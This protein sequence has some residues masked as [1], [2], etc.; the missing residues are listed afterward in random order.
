MHAAEIA[1]ASNP[2]ERLS[3]C[4]SGHSDATSARQ[5][6]LQSLYNSV[7]FRSLWGEESR[8][9]A[10]ED[11]VSQLTNDGLNIANY[12]PKAS[13][14]TDFCHDVALTQGYLQALYDLRFG[15]VDRQSI[16]PLWREQPVNL[17][18]R[19]YFITEHA[20]RH[21]HAPD[22]AFEAVRPRSAQYHGLR[23][24]YAERLRSQQHDLPKVPSGTLLKPGTYDERVRLIAKRLE[25]Q[26]YGPF[27]ATDMYDSA[28]VEA[29]KAFQARYNLQADGVIGPR[30]LEVLNQSSA[31][32]LRQVRVNLERWR[33]LEHEQEPEQLLV[34][35][36][37]GLL[38]YEKDGHVI[39]HGRTQVGRLKRKTPEIK[40]HL[41]RVTLNPTWT[42]PPTIMRE[43][44]LPKIRQDH[45]YLARNNMRVLD[46]NGNVVSPSSV[47]WSNPGA[48]MV[49]QQPGRGNPLGKMV[50]RFNNPYSIYLHDT[51][52]QHLFN[53]SPRDFSSGCVR[54]E[55]IA[56]LLEK[57]MNTDEFARA[58]KAL[59]TGRTHNLAIEAH[60]PIL[61]AYWTAQINAN[62]HLELRPDIYQ[63]D[64]KLAQA[65]D[66][67]K[68]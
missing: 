16:Q 62:G 49:R 65:L 24:L 44:K 1:V 34:D 47:N 30:S 6:S 19:W 14:S 48:Y 28:L 57:L 13:S 33:W 29:V 60:T 64:D 35:I 45:G 36:A 9:K 53:R 8:R 20:K 46:R 17:E 55:G 18:A 39:W 41:T 22:A 21:I 66:H 42:I 15:A 68:K 37:G 3:A 59:A 11:S 58:Q 61:L 5:R 4:I 25:A 63:L 10:L 12:R 51:P 56:V 26:G 23:K 2:N 32:Q 43:D 54:V 50:L 31:D 67:V 40:A 7:E 27:N 52:S 38:S